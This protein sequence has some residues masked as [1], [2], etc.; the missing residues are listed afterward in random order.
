MRDSFVIRRA[1]ASSARPAAA[2]SAIE[3][4][5]TRCTAVQGLQSRHSTERPVTSKT[6]AQIRE[7]SLCYISSKTAK[8]CAAS[9][10]KKSVRP[11]G[12]AEHSTLVR[13]RPRTCS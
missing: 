3:P 9:T 13:N 6:T 7:S 10:S 12:A 4:H 8:L 2:S 1:G 11:P 5:S